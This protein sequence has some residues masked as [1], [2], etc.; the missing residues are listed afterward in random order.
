[1]NTA[2]SKNHVPQKITL[3]ETGTF[4]R[5]ENQDMVRDNVHPTTGKSQVSG[6]GWQYDRK[7]NQ[8]YWAAF[9]PFQPDLNYR[10]PEVK[11][12]IFSILE[13]WLKKGSRWF[14]T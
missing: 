13:Y 7:T 1:M 10:N 8:W 5:T 2:G 4:G 14:S 3:N 6:S 11:K 9:L 12:E